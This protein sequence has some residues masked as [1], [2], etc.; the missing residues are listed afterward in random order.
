MR[1]SSRQSRFSTSLR[2][3]RSQERES[4]NLSFRTNNLWEILSDFLTCCC[5][6]CCEVTRLFACIRSAPATQKQFQFRTSSRP[7]QPL[8]TRCYS[9]R[10]NPATRWSMSS[11]TQFPTYE[12]MLRP[13]LAVAATQDITRRD[14]TET[15]PERALRVDPATLLPKVPETSILGIEAPIW[16]ETLA[17]VSDVEFMAFPRI[18]AV[19]EVAWS[20]QD[21]RVWGGVQGKAWHQCILVAEDR[22]AAVNT[23]GGS[24][25]PGTSFAGR[26]TWPTWSSR[27]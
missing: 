10:A 27:P 13:I 25:V 14:V 21:S 1:V 12:Q 8:R 11:E 16:F 19:A 18:A 3:W 23:E 5:E 24:R 26:P 2:G 22:M 6:A 9:L 7:R 4:S 15:I 17:S 20:P